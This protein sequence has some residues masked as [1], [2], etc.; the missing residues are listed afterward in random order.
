MANLPKFSMNIETGE[1]QS[2]TDN[3]AFDKLQNFPVFLL[4]KKDN[5]WIVDDSFMNIT[6]W[7]IPII[8]KE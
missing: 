3:V 7:L 2:K 4:D 5:R 1:K 8:R 6:S